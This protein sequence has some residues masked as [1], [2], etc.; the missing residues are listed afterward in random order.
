MDSR[1]QKIRHTP[2]VKETIPK[3]LEADQQINHAAKLEPNRYS[4]L[5]AQLH[6]VFPH[7]HCHF[8]TSLDLLAPRHE[9]AN[10]MYNKI[11]HKP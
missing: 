10:N 6:W 8:P 2:L 9:D 11:E 1:T 4:Q 7:L 3:S 5:Q